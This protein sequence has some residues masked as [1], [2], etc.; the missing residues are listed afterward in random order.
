MRQDKERQS[1]TK[2]R[3]YEVRGGSRSWHGGEESND[4]RSS[5][6]SCIRRQSWSNPQN[7]LCYRNYYLFD[8]FQLSSC[9]SYISMTL[10]ALPGMKKGAGFPEGQK[11]KEKKPKTNKQKTKAL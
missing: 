5:L 1:Q 8:R 4:S 7:H 11:K 6:F 10:L 3:E 2:Q 9:P